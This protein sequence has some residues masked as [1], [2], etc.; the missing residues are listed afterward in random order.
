M[1]NANSPL[2][3]GISDADRKKLYNCLFAREVKFDAGAEICSYKSEN[4]VLGMISQGKGEI[5]KIDR[6]GNST[7]LE[8]LNKFSVFSDLFAYTATDANFIG[9]YAT[10]PTTVTFFDYGA[11]FKRCKNACSYH[12]IFVSNLVN[13]VITK[14]K[15]LSQRVE[16]LSNKTIRDKILSY[17]SITVKTLGTPSFDL[18]MSLTQFAEY[19]C[20]D[21]SAMMRELKKL[22]EQGILKVNKRNFNVL[23]KEYI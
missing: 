8:Q 2:F 22:N 15:L 13:I 14:S 18:P 7:I 3:V 17:V 23:S 20:V 12:S 21:R 16:I 11:V 6:N 9:V 10:E 1:K 5:R 19:L 4:G